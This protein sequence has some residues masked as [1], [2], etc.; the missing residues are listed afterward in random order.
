MININPLIK[1][2]AMLW[3]FM[4]L[5]K[6]QISTLLILIDLDLNSMRKYQDLDVIIMFLP[7]IHKEIIK[8]LILKIQEFDH[9][10]IKK[11]INFMVVFIAIAMN[12][13]IL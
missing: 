9:F 3:V 11:K 10:L 6:L 7:S 4:N 1:M 2:D 13:V 8:F 5:Q 12:Y